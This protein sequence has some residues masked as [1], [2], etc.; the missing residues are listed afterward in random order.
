MPIEIGG[1]VAVQV[2][3]SVELPL[4]G[5]PTRTDGVRHGRRRRQGRE[6]GR[7]GRAQVQGTITY[8]DGREEAYE[9]GGGRVGRVG[10]ATRPGT[11]IP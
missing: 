7:V 8:K 11:A 9:T 4:V 2:V 10:D 3:T 5:E 6:K 1:D